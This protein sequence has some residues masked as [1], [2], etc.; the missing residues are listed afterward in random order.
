MQND[1]QGSALREVGTASE[2]KFQKKGEQP[3]T[4]FLLLYFC[5]VISTKFSS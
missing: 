3:G 5:T 4:N 2:R 1:L